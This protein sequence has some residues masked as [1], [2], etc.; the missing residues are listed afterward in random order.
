MKAVDEASK[1]IQHQ[2]GRQGGQMLV[3]LNSCLI[4]NRV[5]DM[6]FLEAFLHLFVL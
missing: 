1:G 6:T 4:W 2:W 3:P 5:L